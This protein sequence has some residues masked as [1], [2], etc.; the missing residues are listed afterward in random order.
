MAREEQDREDL[1]REATALVERVEFLVEGKSIVVGFRP[2]GAGSLFFEN[3]PAYH[4][5]ATG[6]LRRAYVAGMLYK[7]ERGRLVALQRMR[8]EREV[9]LMRHQVDETQTSDFLRS[10]EDRMK[11]LQLAIDEQRAAV[12]SQIPADG[13]VVDRVV[14]WLAQLA[15]TTKIAQSPRV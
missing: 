10:L 7:A 11:S 6:E 3:D 2:N 15:G 4:F 8:S 9:A 5:S 1:M 14:R 13:M 12:L